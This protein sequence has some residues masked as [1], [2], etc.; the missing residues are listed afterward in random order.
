MNK[1]LSNQTFHVF[2]NP[3][4]RISVMY[5]T[6]FI[7]LEER[8]GILSTRQFSRF[9]SIIRWSGYVPP[10]RSVQL[11]SEMRLLLFDGARVADQA[12]EL[13][14]SQLEAVQRKWRGLKC[15]SPSDLGP[16]FSFTDSLTADTQFCAGRR[17]GP[18]VPRRLMRSS[19]FSWFVFRPPEQ[20]T[21]H[22]Q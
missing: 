8:L 22:S 5:C 11:I 16:P 7:F 6:A 1:T 3:S 14:A 20:L 21:L 2:K 15:I 19:Q 4:H 10:T 12:A 18:M 9:V 17:T 13:S